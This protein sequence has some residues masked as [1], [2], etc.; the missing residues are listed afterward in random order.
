M[1]RLDD[2]VVALRE[3]GDDPADDVAARQRLRRSLDT[4]P[5][6]TSWGVVAALVLATSASWAFATGRLQGLLSRDGGEPPPSVTA[7][8]GDPAPPARHLNTKTHDPPPPPEPPPPPAA[9]PATQPVVATAPRRSRVADVPAPTRSARY[10][11]AHELYF[12]AADYTAALQ[13]FDDYL[14]SEPGGA[15]VVEARYN[16][17]LCLVRLGRLDDARTALQPFADGEVLA[18]YRQ[19][20]AR[21]LI[22]KIDRRLNGT[23]RCGDGCP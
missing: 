15:F 2:H 11:R 6:T 22:E 1:T 9:P 21:S 10:A 20:D 12:H 23:A 13:A 18:G 4:R 17:A 3:L 14:A 8:H 7:P 16:R 19:Q 5:R